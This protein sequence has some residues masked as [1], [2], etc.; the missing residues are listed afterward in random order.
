[1]GDPRYTSRSENSTALTCAVLDEDVQVWDHRTKCRAGKMPLAAKFGETFMPW[2]TGDCPLDEGFGWPFPSTR[3]DEIGG[4]NG[5]AYS[6]KCWSADSEKGLG[7]VCYDLQS[8]DRDKRIFNYTSTL[9]EGFHQVNAFSIQAWSVEENKYL[10]PPDMSY[11]YSHDFDPTTLDT[12]A[13]RHV[14]FSEAFAIDKEAHECRC[15]FDAFCDSKGVC[16]AMTCE[17]IFRFGPTTRENFAN[18]ELQCTTEPVTLHCQDISTVTPLLSNDTSH[19]C[20]TSFPSA[21]SAAM[22]CPSQCDRGSY[23]LRTSNDGPT[24]KFLR[25]CTAT[26]EAEDE[27]EIHTHT[28]SCH[29]MVGTDVET[30]DSFLQDVLD[31]PLNCSVADPDPDH[32]ESATVDNDLTQEPETNDCDESVTDENDLTGEPESLGWRDVRFF[33]RRNLD[34]DYFN[35]Q[36]WWDPPRLV[37]DEFITM[38]TLMVTMDVEVSSESRGL[39]EPESSSTISISKTMLLG[40]IV[41]LL[42]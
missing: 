38:R 16:H 36:P 10:D 30:F 26:V 29:D 14:M 39:P 19:N 24:L 2:A 18:A 32:D 27:F 12:V 23:Q 11:A 21:V 40:T 28:F 42:L 22:W 3:P 4:I 17:N 35:R 1:M 34:Y 9:Q 7:F 41:S 13:L 37:F 33:D 31:S 5:L 25:I 15:L 8:Q 6:R 20:E